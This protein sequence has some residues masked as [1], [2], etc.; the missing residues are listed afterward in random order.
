[1]SPLG[2]RAGKPV[3]TLR[4]SST[5]G[6][7]EVAPEPGR[8]VRFG[9]GG[10]E[11]ERRVE[12]RVGTHDD[13]V[14]RRQGEL[15]FQDGS[16][17]L[18]NIGKAKLRLPGSSWPLQR[19]DKGDE[20]IPLDFGRTQ[21][22]VV[23]SKGREYQ[24]ELFVFD[25]TP[26]REP[27][28]RPTI[29]PK[30]WRL[31]ED[32]RRVLAVMGQRYLR[33]EPNPR[34]LTYRETACQLRLLRLE[35]MWGEKW[36]T[37]RLGLSSEEFLARLE[38]KTERTVGQARKRLSREGF[39]DLERQPDQPYDDTLKRN[40]VEGLVAS[41]TLTQNDLDLLENES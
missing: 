39:P 18:R 19:L 9:R 16:W 5:S 17:W 29:S 15:T 1:M 34:P 38:K 14:S 12:L 4:A 21:V 24:V 28:D 30:R 41:T 40:L 3:K 36:T 22:Q 20:P 27:Y 31:L 7:V 23:G 26:P 33:Q 35:R 25:E 32:E 37:K 10:S 8:V 11:R 2:R 6:A 13:H